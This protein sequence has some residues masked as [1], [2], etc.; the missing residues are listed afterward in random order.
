MSRNQHSVT[1]EHPVVQTNI[2]TGRI[3]CKRCID[4]EACRT[5]IAWSVHVLWHNCELCK[6]GQTNRD[7]VW[8]SDSYR[9]KELSISLNGRHLANTSER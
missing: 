3:T 6:N 1:S 4:A 7:A 5:Y 2:S 9:P 8:V